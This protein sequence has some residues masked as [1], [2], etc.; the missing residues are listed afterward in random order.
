MGGDI[1]M[2]KRMNRFAEG[3]AP[4]RLDTDPVMVLAYL[5]RESRWASEHA[6]ENKGA[7]LRATD[8][9]RS[10]IDS[11]G[12]LVLTVG[13]ERES[14]YWLY[15]AREIEQ[16]VWADAM[17]GTRGRHV[18]G[19]GRLLRDERIA[20]ARSLEDR[21]SD[22]ADE[23]IGTK[24]DLSQAP[25]A[26][27]AVRAFLAAGHVHLH[28]MDEGEV[29]S[30]LEF[31]TGTIIAPTL[32]ETIE[33][34]VGQLTLFMVASTWSPHL[35]RCPRCGRYFVRKVVW[36]LAPLCNKRCRIRNKDDKKKVRQRAARLDQQL[37]ALRAA[38]A[39]MK[40]FPPRW[41]NMAARKANTKL[42]PDRWIGVRF[43]AHH[44]GEA[45]LREA[46]APRE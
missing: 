42:P 10:H 7:V 16:I 40:T 2:S 37:A 18:K 32:E 38:L 29:T 8:E 46:G 44:C 23:W 15:R 39:T 22:L 28:T 41:K 12:A 30:D 5:N 19:W 21:L 9:D 13:D 6:S 31:G 45:D 11:S 17:R 1:K 20:A 25:K 24:K 43:V 26:T 33:L 14:E 35:Y 34:K 3:A 4:F 36:A 27:E